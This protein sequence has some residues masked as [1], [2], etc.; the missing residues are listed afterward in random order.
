[1]SPLKTPEA[2][3]HALPLLAVACGVACGCDLVYPEVAVIN[4]TA[5]A[6]LLRNLSFSGCAWPSVLAHGQATALERC[7]PGT[8]RIHFEKLELPREHTEDTSADAPP[9]WFRYQTR[10]PRQVAYGEQRVLEVT[11]DELEQDFS[12][13]GPVGH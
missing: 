8:D 4:R 11:L 5:P 2:T 13:P 6:I 12:Q 1:M 9:T 3:R 7:L 10:S